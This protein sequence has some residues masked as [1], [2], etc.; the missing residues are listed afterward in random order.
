MSSFNSALTAGQLVSLRG[1][2]STPNSY[3]NRISISSNANT[4]IYSAR[5]NQATFDNQVVAITYDGGV[6]TLGNVRVGMTVLISHTSNIRD[7]FFRGRIRLDP[8]A[9]V[10][11]IN[12]TSGSELLDDDYIFVIDDFDTHIRFPAPQ[13]TIKIDWDEDYN[14]LGPLISNLQTAYPGFVTSSVLTLVLAPTVIAAESGN[15][16]STYLWEVADGTITVGTSS[17][18][19]IT[20]T[21]P[22]GERWIH[23]TATD[24]GGLTTTRHIKVWAHDSNNPPAPLSVRGVSISCE[25]P[26]AINA[27]AGEGWQGSVTY[28]DGVENLLDQTFVTIWNDEKYNGVS[29]NIVNNI[30]MVGRFRSEQSSTPIDP[31]T[32]QIDPTTTFSVEGPLAQLGRID[33]PSF[34]AQLGSGA[35]TDIIKVN[36]LTLWR[37]VWLVLSKF[38]TF[39]SLYSVSFDDTSDD[40]LFPELLTQ[41]GDL[42]SSVADLAQSITASFESNQAG[43]CQIVRRGNMLDD[44]GRAALVSVAEITTSDILLEFSNQR[45]YPGVIGILEASGGGYNSSSGEVSKYISEA[46]AGTPK[47]PPGEGQLHRQVL[48]S[49]QSVADEK[50]ELIERSGNAFAAQQSP[51]IV[52]L[53]LNAPWGFLTPSANQ[54]YPL[55][56]PASLTARGIVYDSNTRWWLQAISPTPSVQGGTR[57]VVGT[58]VKETDGSD[59]AII[60]AQNINTGLY[61]VEV[62]EFNESYELPPIDDLPDIDDFSIDDGGW[63]A[64]PGTHSP[65][66]G[67]IPACVGGTSEY[68]DMIKVFDETKT[69]TSILVTYNATY[70]GGADNDN[71]IMIR[72]SGGAWQAIAVGTTQ[73]GNGKTFAVNFEAPVDEVRVI[74]YAGGNDCTGSLVVTSVEWTEIT[75]DFWTH[76]FNFLIESGGFTPF[77]VGPPRSEW[78]GGVGW[79]N[80][81][82]PANFRLVQFERS[83]SS[84]FINTV[85]WV[86]TEALPGGAGVDLRAPDENA[87]DF[88]QS[89]NKDLLLQQFTLNVTT[90][91]L[92]INVDNGGAGEYFG[93]VTSL[94]VTGRG[95]NPF[96]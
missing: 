16:I 42:L 74:M 4:V 20:V 48:V 85:W 76:T 90:D 75:P 11:Y 54:W 2:S 10:L 1:D 23:F 40:F 70:A 93:A 13:D 28:F 44:S 57:D 79:V 43:E 55:D 69:L 50:T 64:D 38:S 52:N 47:E 18:K 96:L 88:G 6:G 36:D 86:I 58:F 65:G 22:A 12:E 84:T 19:D 46:P 14:G 3:Q 60:P 8:T 24:S 17:T 51:E 53:G 81:G 63:T 78:K 31:T 21:F 37:M 32:S 5:A 39:G 92:W 34:I 73:S 49:D 35:T 87:S 25:I 41:G 15:T 66:S 61:G 68:I 94:T 9:T 26:I 91:G 33:A 71:R 82:N 80:S 7:A 29:V 45:E 62:G 95:V 72:A 59:G 30:A 77:A 67:W 89:G 83:F 27:G 56:I